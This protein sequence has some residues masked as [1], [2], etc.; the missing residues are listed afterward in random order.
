MQRVLAAARAELLE[1]ETVGRITTILRR[2]VIALLALGACE[3]DARTNIGALAS[4][5]PPL[6]VYRIVPARLYRPAGSRSERVTRTL[7]LTIMSRTL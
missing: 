5:F 6:F 1:F 4:H 3:R 7:D 2:D